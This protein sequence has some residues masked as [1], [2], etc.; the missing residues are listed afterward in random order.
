MELLQQAHHDHPTLTEGV[1]SRS[2]VLRR[3][4]AIQVR[5]IDPIKPADR[6]AR[7]NLPERN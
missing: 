4:T 1:L 3:H 7:R 2:I 6:S 5:P